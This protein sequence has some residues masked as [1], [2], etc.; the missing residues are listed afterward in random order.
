MNSSSVSDEVSNDRQISVLNPGFS[1]AIPNLLRPHPQNSAIYGEDENVSSLIDLIQASGWVKPLVVTP[2]GTII[3]GHRRWK[4][5]LALEWES[6]P[7]EVREFPDELTELEALLLENASRLKTTEQKVREGEAWQDLEASKAKIRQTA[8]LKTGNQIPVRENFPTRERGR[9]RDAIASRVGLGSGRT[10]EKAAAVVR[11]IDELLYDTPETAKAF[12]KVLNEHSVDAAHR[13]LKKPAPIRQQVLSLIAEGKAKSIKQAERIVKQNHAEFNN[14]SRPTLGGFSVGDWVEVNEDTQNPTYVGFRGQVEQILTVE[15][16][17]AVNLE[18]SEDRAAKVRFYP[19]ELTLIGK[20]QPPS[21]F[22]VGDLVFVNIDHLE[23]ASPEERKWN[24]YWGL[25][26]AI[27]ETGGLTVNVGSESL[28]L[29]SRD[30]KPIDAQSTELH[31][32]VER[33]LWLRNFALDEIEQRMLDVLQ[34]RE[35]F[36]PNQL[37]HLKNIETLYLDAKFHETEKPQ[38]SKFQGFPHLNFDSYPLNL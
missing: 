18:D 32:V 25:V 3:S 37:I 12:K 34:R 10:Y 21:P 11:E 4:A 15:S 29:F 2:T 35:W 28:Q 13:L 24:G 27:G 31:Q 6:I 30:L 8:N 33:V 7:V 9:V 23:A 22:Q 19:H 26:T 1:S 14:P 20:A 5:V 17:I 38:A 16:Q 36:T